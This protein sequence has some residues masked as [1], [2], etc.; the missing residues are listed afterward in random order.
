[1]KRMSING[2][3]FEVKKKG[4]ISFYNECMCRTLDDCYAKPSDIKKAIWKEWCEFFRPFYSNFAIGCF[5]NSYNC[6]VYTIGAQIEVDNVHYNVL[7]TPV[8]NY[9]AEV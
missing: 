1:M 8:H 3:E 9:I 4:S 2:V 6:M 5:V 7:I